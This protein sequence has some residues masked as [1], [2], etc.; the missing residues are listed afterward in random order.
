MKTFNFLS[1]AKSINIQNDKSLKI[2]N[3]NQN[4]SGNNNNEDNSKL[5]NPKLNMPIN[6]SHT[7]KKSHRERLYRFKNSC[8]KICR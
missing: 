7:Y 2:K 8:K 3:S 6:Q 1:N 5:G 4:T